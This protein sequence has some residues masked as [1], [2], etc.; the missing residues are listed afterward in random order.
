MTKKKSKTK[1]T[2]LSTTLP[3]ILTR[4]IQ[5]HNAGELNE[6]IK[7]YEQI[8][9]IN[10]KHIDALHLYG[11][12][13][14][15]QGE[16]KKALELVKRSITINDAIANI[17]NTYAS[18]LLALN[19]QDEAIV[20]LKRA[21]HL[22]P[23]HYLAWNNLGNTQR[24]KGEYAAAKI[25]YDAALKLNPYDPETLTLSCFIRQHL[26]D[27][28]ELDSLRHRFMTLV[29]QPEHQRIAPFTV[30]SLVAD[31]IIQKKWASHFAAETASGL[32]RQKTTNDHHQ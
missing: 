26:C 25:A 20:A 16:F 4:G 1:H 19:N 17:Y 29:P 30:L 11:L 6:A 10:P 14:Y 32:S 22:D 7:D 24:D 31:P 28:E 27:W 13:C 3:D 21:V 9:K 8:L 15:Q 5:A 18:I 23:Y 12:A 2:A